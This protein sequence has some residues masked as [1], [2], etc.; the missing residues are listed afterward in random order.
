MYCT[1]TIK[2]RRTVPVPLQK[3]AYRTYVQYQT[4]ILCFGYWK[5]HQTIVTQISIEL[6]S[7]WVGF[8]VQNEVISKKK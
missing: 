2:K 7:P 4:A 3:K 1:R 5:K 8:F 6:W